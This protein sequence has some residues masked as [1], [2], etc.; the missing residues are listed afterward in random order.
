MPSPPFC[1]AV[2]FAMRQWF[3]IS[4]PWLPKPRTMPSSTVIRSPEPEIPV[5]LLAVQLRPE[6][7]PVQVPPPATVKP[8]RSSVTSLAVMSIAD[9]SRGAVRLLVSR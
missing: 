6:P 7:V 4:I 8:F 3:P 1:M 5:P 2:T 9:V